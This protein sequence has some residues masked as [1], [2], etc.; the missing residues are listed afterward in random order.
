MHFEFRR[1]LLPSLAPDEIF[2]V[3]TRSNRWSVHLLKRDE[4]HWPD[5]GM[6]E[7]GGFYYDPDSSSLPGIPEWLDS[8]P[9]RMR[10]ALQ[11]DRM[12]TPFL[13][14]WASATFAKDEL[15]DLTATP[16]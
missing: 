3:E 9:Q 16:A 14:G 2:L 12:Y 7:L 13:P 4:A 5:T 8:I 11:L 6:R 1:D 15:D 10:N